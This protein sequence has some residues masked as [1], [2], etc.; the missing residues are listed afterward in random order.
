[1]QHYKKIG[2]GGGCH[3]CTEAVFQHITGVHEVLQGYIAAEGA[4]ADFSEGVIVTY[5]PNV[6]SLTQLIEVHLRTHQATVSHSF[7]KKY[8]SAVYY[9]EQ[10]QKASAQ[11][12]LQELQQ[13]FQAPII[14]KVLP[15]VQFSPSRESL[16]NYFRKNPTAPF[17]ERYILPKLA[18]LK[19]RS[20]ITSTKG[21]IPFCVR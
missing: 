8:R 11:A 15:H 16:Q 13:Y 4:Y 9:F 1:M 19:E 17:C 20:L 21:D 6:I 18:K 2:F 3:W 5:D 7:R 14:T 12:A 10:E